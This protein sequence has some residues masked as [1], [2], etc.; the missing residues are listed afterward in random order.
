[1]STRVNDG[2]PAYPAA[3]N[4]NYTDDAQLGQRG[5][6]V[7]DWFAGQALPAKIKDA[8]SFNDDCRNNRN[9]TRITPEDVAHSCYVYADAMLK[10][11]ETKP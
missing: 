10:A 8:D 7:R 9:N 5:M 3:P 2:G 6:S 11:R 4:P 1:M